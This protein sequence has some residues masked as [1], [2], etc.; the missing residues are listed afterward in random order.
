LRP[1]NCINNDERLIRKLN[2]NY[3]YSKKVRPSMIKN[4]Y[5]IETAEGIDIELIPAGLAVRSYAFSIDFFIRAAILLGLSM[6][7]G[8]LGDFGL[9]LFFITWFIVEWFYPV[10]FEI[11]KGATPGKSAFGLRVVHDNGLPISFAGALTRNLFRA[12]DMLPFAYAIGAI[13]MVL[14]EKSKRI[15]DIV[16]GTTVVYGA[17]KT[18]A[19]LFNAN[20]DPLEMPSMTTE[21]QQLIVAFAHRSTYLSVAR[22]IELASVLSPVINA[23]GEEAIAKLKSIAAVIIGKT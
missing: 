12:I 21:Q 7:F 5:Q 8:Y 17:E 20:K 22:Q 4:N 23:E 16:A 15:G 2:F 9:G 18:K 3:G 1:E 19:I 11:Y 10:I 6:L 14:N 13:S